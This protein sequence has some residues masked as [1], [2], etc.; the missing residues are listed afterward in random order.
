M[1]QQQ[2]VNKVHD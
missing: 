1:K 2:L